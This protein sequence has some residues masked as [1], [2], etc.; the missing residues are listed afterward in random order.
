[1]IVKG[2]IVNVLSNKYRY[3]V[4]IPVFDTAGIN[5][6]S[7]F[8]CGVCNEPGVTQGYKEGDIV[9]VGFENN[10]LNHPIIIGKFF[11]NSY[12]DNDNLS[13][14]KTSTLDVKDGASLPSNTTVG[15]IN[16]WNI[17]NYIAPFGVIE[18]NKLYNNMSNYTNNEVVVGSW[19]N[20]ENIYRRVFI[21]PFKS[22][23]PNI[24]IKVS[25]LETSISS[26]ININYTCVPIALVGNE[27]FYNGT[28]LSIGVR[29]AASSGDIYV[30]STNTSSQ[31]IRQ[32]ILIIEYTK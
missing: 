31:S 1:M 10:S 26:V 27:S 6:K 21:V 28:Y 23:S 8:E 4:H 13:S 3:N 9:I 2:E 24:E 12:A 19:I 20:G 18:D 11:T 5:T 29:V 25:S 22:L 16:L 7:I 15:G 17:M 30:K 32:I 14:I